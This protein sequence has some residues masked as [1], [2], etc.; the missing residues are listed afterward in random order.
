MT[1]EEK[2]RD[3]IRQMH[4]RATNAPW[5]LSAE[6]VRSQRR[7]ALRMPSPKVL[8]LAAAAIVIILLVVLVGTSNGSGGHRSR[9]PVAV[10]PTSTTTTTPASTTTTTSGPSRV[11]VP[12]LVGENRAQAISNLAN[13]GLTVGQIRLIPSASAANVV[14]SQAPSA[15]SIVA[16]GSTV[17]ITVSSGP[18][19]TA[20]NQR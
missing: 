3:L 7:R 19:E 2:V 10:P 20:A 1:E 4:E 18:S 17:M 6:D 13:L 5:S 16:A 9:R 12:D 11:T 15:G 8:G 14:V